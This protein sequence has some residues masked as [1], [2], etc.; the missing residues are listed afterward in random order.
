MIVAALIA[1]AGHSAHFAATCF[2]YESSSFT[3]T[4]RCKG[5]PVQKGHV[6]ARWRSESDYFLSSSHAQV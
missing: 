2:M 1:V 4:G 6:S 3:E 5:L